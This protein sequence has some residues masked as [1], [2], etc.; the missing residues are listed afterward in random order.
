MRDNLKNYRPLFFGLALI[1]VGNGLQ[2]TLLSVRAD[3][4]GFSTLTTGLI[5]SLYYAGFLAGSIFAPKLVSN[6]GHIRVFS[7]LASLASAMTLF[8]GAFVD[9][10]SWAA[11]R[12]ITGFCFAGIYIVIES[13][14]NDVSNN[15]NRGQILGT[16]L[17]VFYGAMVAGQYLLNVASPEDIELFIIV[18]VLVSLALLPIS[19]SKR[20]A[21]EFSEP[22]PASIKD[23]YTASPLGVVGVCVSGLTVGIFF[24]MG[25]VFANQSGFTIA[26]TA[27]FMACFVMGGMLAQVPIGYLSDRIERRKVIITVSILAC[28]ASFLC[29]FSSGHQTL[30]YAMAMFLGASSL[31]IYG[32]C[33][34]YTNDHLPAKKYV[35]A[36][37]RLILLNGSAALVGPLLAAGFMTLFGFQIFFVVIGVIFTFITL[38]ALYRTN[39]SDA[40]AMEDQ[41][42]YISVSPRATPFLAQIAEEDILYPEETEARQNRP[43][44]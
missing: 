24:A 25:P 38:F 22:E 37:A 8:H 7:A 20:P 30:I 29:Y 42:D 31:S 28:I 15:D 19:L 13:W 9:P 6:V 2:G 5:M 39:V 10:V 18:S 12:V 33:V 40:V 35:A 27:N 3:I 14:L 11:A 44:D 16:Y 26:Q 4:E 1:M 34:A 23:V 41:V 32:L 21:P 17:F 36:S 43:D